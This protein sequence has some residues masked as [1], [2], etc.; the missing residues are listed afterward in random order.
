MFIN[1]LFSLFFFCMSAVSLFFFC[2]FAVSLFLASFCP[3]IYCTDF[4]RIFTSRHLCAIIRQ[5]RISLSLYRCTPLPVTVLF[6]LLVIAAQGV[7]NRSEIDLTDAVRPTIRTITGYTITYFEYFLYKWS[8][9][10]KAC[11]IIW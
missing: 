1:H 9:V 4:V 10:C 11:K 8:T 6:S 5:Y 2:M 3:S 7:R